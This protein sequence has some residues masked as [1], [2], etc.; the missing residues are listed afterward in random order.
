MKKRI[1]ALVLMVCMISPLM[2]TGIS[3]QELES[4]VFVKENFNGCILGEKPSDVFSVRYSGSG[5]M[6]I[7][8][9]NSNANKCLLIRCDGIG[10][11]AVEKE[12]LNPDKL[13]L[14]LSYRFK[15]KDGDGNFSM[16]S[17][18]DGENCVS[19]FEINNNDICLDGESLGNVENDKWYYCEITFNLSKKTFSL[20]L[21]GKKIIKNKE[22]AIDEISK[23]SFKINN[24]KR[25][26]Y[27]D[28]VYLRK[29]GMGSTNGEYFEDSL[30][31]LK[32]MEQSEVNDIALD[33]VLMYE[34]K[35]K[36]IANGKVVM[37][38]APPVAQDGAL[39]VSLRFVCESFGGSVAWSGNEA[40]VVYNEKQYTVK[41]GDMSIASDNVSIS[42]SSPIVMHNG[43]VYIRVEDLCALIEQTYLIDDGLIVLGDGVEYYATS[44]DKIKD[45][46]KNM[47][48]YTRPGGEEVIASLVKKHPDNSHPRILATK[49]S[50]EN[51]KNLINTDSF[52][53]ECFIALEK[54]ADDIL[55]KKLVSY[56]L[57]GG[58][59]VSADEDI[60]KRMEVLGLVW[61]V[62]KNDKYAE[63]AWKELNELINFPD[64]NHLGTFLDA[65]QCMY[66]AALGYDM[67]Y[68]YLSQEQRAALRNGLI[69]HGL[70]PARK[71]YTGEYNVDE[72]RYT[73]FWVS[74]PFNWN[75][76]GNRGTLAACLAICD[77]EPS[78]TA[79]LLEYALR[80]LEIHF[81]E[82]EPDGGWHEG[83]DY[84]YST[85]NG[86]AIILS[87]FLNALSDDF[88]YSDI[89]G[90]KAASRFPAYMLSSGGLFNFSDGNPILK[91][92][93]IFANIF[94]KHLNDA[95][96]AA[97]R[98]ED[99]IS[100][101]YS[102]RAIDL[103]WYS[104]E[105][106]DGKIEEYDRDKYFRDVETTVSR[107][108]WSD[109]GIFAGFHSGPN[110]VNHAH[111]DTCS[112]IYDYGGI[113]WFH[114]IPHDPISYSSAEFTC[115]TNRAE[116]HNTLV[117]D[118]T[119]YN[120]VDQN[121]DG[122]LEYQKCLDFEGYGVGDAP[123][124]DISYKE[125]TNGKITIQ[126]ENDGNKYLN[127]ESSSMSTTGGG[128]IN[129]EIPSPYAADDFE[130]DFKFRM[131]DMSMF[132][133]DEWKPLEMGIDP[134]NRADRWFP[135]YVNSSGIIAFNNDRAVLL[136]RTV[137]D[138][139]YSV[140]LQLHP[141]TQT[142]DVYID[143]EKVANGFVPTKT[144]TAVWLAR[145]T[146][147]SATTSVGFDDIAIHVGKGDN[148][149]TKATARRY[150][151][152]VK[153]DSKITRFESKDFGS[154]SVSDM[155]SAYSDNANSA[156]RGIM[157]TDN[158]K[159]VVIRDEVSLKKKSDVYWFAHYSSAHNMKIADDKKSAIL[160]N[161]DKSIWIGII[162]DGDYSFEIMNAR[163]L[164][165]SPDPEG[166]S[167]NDEWKKLTVK[168][169]GVTEFDLEVAIIPLM[170]SQNTPDNI[171][172]SENLDSWQL[173]DSKQ[174][175]LTSLKINGADV[176]GFDPQ[177]NI[178][179]I[180]WTSTAVPEVWAE[181]E[182]GTVKITNAS[183]VPGYAT[184]EVTDGIDRSVYYIGFETENII[185]NKIQ[186]YDIT[187][188]DITVSGAETGDQGGEKTI[189]DNL[190]TRWV[191][192]GTGNW[193]IYDFKEQCTFNKLQI[194]WYYG[195][196][197]QY[198]FIIQVSKDGETWETAYNG[199]SSGLSNELEE[200]RFNSCSGRYL[201]I[202][203][204]CYGD[205]SNPY[206]NIAEVK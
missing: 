198:K 205:D 99:I 120:Y 111:L 92:D 19:L 134:A 136:K 16:L 64:W 203:C 101:N 151:Q 79:P 132:V 144:F 149:I 65:G 95:N 170:P 182:R 114:D 27:L 71:A 59:M 145:I 107:S 177:K 146:F 20:S 55:T 174:I 188:K 78:Y 21:D 98:K 52:A 61:Q 83:S 68:D 82:W 75:L 138:E 26:V 201:K 202:I 112:F 72:N 31:F 56:E 86:D 187:E 10:E 30:L 135:L 38:I 126:E 77:E 156:V 84:G 85:L 154:I 130:L 17:I 58:Q 162:S 204:N 125:A 183:N 33:S 9:D 18:G 110:Y 129:W 32:P 106:A 176:S 81:N 42:L 166:Q 196:G 194:A 140:K 94:A 73:C 109:D 88:G 153:G 164:P 195:I 178:Y 35:T 63:R 143:G 74:D 105:L 117:I 191:T 12:F 118:E 119:P 122:M 66:G 190:S 161:G 14:D 2:I 15:L 103:L 46:V 197:R 57:S 116:G 29:A 186:G 179:N 100:K 173:P 6:A 142:M 169:S 108:D 34:T 137:V 148:E 80:S 104:P 206:N 22:F 171:P 131:P 113:R 102:L 53:R 87:I 97:R 160:S 70:E 159:T 13:S 133:Q 62:T 1:V 199:T 124:S 157:L 150:D 7:V 93:F 175:N 91:P 141:K 41:P 11:V 165:Y 180:K 200:Y 51:V 181:A 152:E 192:S 40:K 184:V 96:L 172:K 43:S 193:I 8:A 127:I 155:T 50:I 49:E 3:A 60:W 69:K 168:A 37:P 28:D 23:I 67:F 90:F 158:R 115:Y 4:G 24:A 5:N 54:E 47:T 48:K 76:V 25:T 163:P 36:A 44:D 167:K 128:F 45:E 147:N 139:W 39:Y 121:S 123:G 189:D 89:E 185:R